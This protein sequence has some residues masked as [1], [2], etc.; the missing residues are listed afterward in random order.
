MVER[1]GVEPVRRFDDGVIGLELKMSVEGIGH[2][3]VAASVK[4]AE[5]RV[6]LG[7]PAGLK[8]GGEQIPA[9]KR[10]GG[11]WDDVSPNRSLMRRSIAAFDASNVWH[12]SFTSPPTRACSRM[13]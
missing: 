4:S 13:T 12:I 8:E 7:V 10:L 6:G 3:R 2:R 9:V 11:H 1:R 5:I